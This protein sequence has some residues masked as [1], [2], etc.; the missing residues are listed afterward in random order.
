MPLSTIRTHLRTGSLSIALLSLLLGSCGPKPA[1]LPSLEGKRVLILG[2]S[3]TQDGRYVAFLEYYLLR[4]QPRAKFDIVSIGLSSETVSGLSEK[5]HPQP[6]PC[7]LER[8]GRALAQVKPQVVLACYGMNDGIYHPPSPERMKAFET[9]LARLVG[10]VRAAGAQLVLLTPPPFDPVPIPTRLAKPEATEF[11]YSAFYPR[12]DEVLG[13]FAQH[14]LALR[15][16][17]VWAI[18]LHGAINHE[19]SARRVGDPAF[20]FSRDGVHPGDLGHLLMARTIAAALGVVVPSATLEDEL[21]RIN[22]DPLFALVREQRKVRSEAWLP[23]IGYTR[24]KVVKTESVDEAER[25]VTELQAQ[26][27]ALRNSATVP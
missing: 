11:G 5:G 26:I 4:A 13:A 22:A 16:P 3:I 19:L 21:A 1:P 27:D 23:F 8:L 7:I 6:R 20:T 12:Y 14:E 9:G 24:D 2:D 10:D 17:G 15:E 25:R 18:D